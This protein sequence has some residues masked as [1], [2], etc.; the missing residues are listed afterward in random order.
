MYSKSPHYGKDVSISGNFMMKTL[1]FHWLPCY[2]GRC[3]H[4]KI[5]WSTVVIKV[6]LSFRNKI[7]YIKVILEEKYAL[8]G[9]NAAVLCGQNP[10]FQRNIPYPPS[11]WNSRSRWQAELIVLPASVGF[12][13]C[14]LF[15]PED[16]GYMFFWNIGLSQATCDSEDHSLHSQHCESLKSN[17]KEPS[18]FTSD[19]T[20]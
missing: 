14:L 2:T 18:R 3:I 16:G 6:R 9:C 17:F 12:L 15:D 11:G 5:L 13:H 20:L 8:L 1:F 19:K 7:R 4:M 10:L